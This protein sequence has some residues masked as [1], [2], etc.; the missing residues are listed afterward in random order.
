MTVP[1]GDKLTHPKDPTRQNYAFDG[2][3]GSD[4]KIVKDSTEIDSDMTLTA[5]FHYK[6]EVS[7]NG[8]SVR[9]IVTLLK[10]IAAKKA[11]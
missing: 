11:K 7:D 1:V 5:K 6:R 8:I 4:G 10:M 9:T 3:Y 2:W